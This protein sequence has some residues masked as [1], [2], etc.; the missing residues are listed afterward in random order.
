MPMKLKPQRPVAQVDLRLAREQSGLGWAELVESGALVRVAVLLSVRVAG[1]WVALWGSVTQQ[2]V[3]SSIRY[4][5]VMRHVATRASDGK[6]RVRWSVLAGVG[7]HGGGTGGESLSLAGLWQEIPFS[8]RSI[9]VVTNVSDSVERWREFAS[10]HVSRRVLRV[11]KIVRLWLIRHPSG[12]F[13]Q[14]WTSLQVVTSRCNRMAV[15]G[16]IRTL[17]VW[18]ATAHTQT[19]LGERESWRDAVLELHSSR[20]RQAAINA[21]D[22][23][24]QA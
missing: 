24:P 3:V 20:R 8:S 1:A 13:F 6:G 15:Q 7:E 4:D 23:R 14:G 2:T 10:L 16:E 19:F 5:R 11:G 18:V 9:E 12:V 17:W 22:V 21:C